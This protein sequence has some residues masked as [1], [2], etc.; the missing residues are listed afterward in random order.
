MPAVSRHESTH[1]DPRPD[2]GPNDGSDEGAHASSNRVAD[3]GTNGKALSVFSCYHGC[4]PDAFPRSPSFSHVRMQ[5]I[6]TPS[7]LAT[8]T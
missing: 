7:W 5:N 8:A 4:R 6:D 1:T 3:N 2:D